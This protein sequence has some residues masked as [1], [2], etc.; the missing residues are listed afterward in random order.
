[1]HYEAFRA[2]WND[3]LRASRLPTVGVYPSETLDTRDL[4]RNYEVVVE[5]LGGQ[6]AS[7]F[8]VTARLSWKWSSLNTVRNATRDEDVLVEMLGRDQASEL[9]IEKPYVPVDIQ[10]R[11]SA[12]YAKPLPMPGRAAWAKWVR[13]TLQRLDH[14]E[15]LLPDEVLRENRMGMTEVLAWQEAPKLK[16]VCSPN[17]ELSLEAV[18]LSAGQIIELPRSLDC[19]DELDEAPDEQLTELFARVRASLMAWTQAVD[20]LGRR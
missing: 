8:H 4:D 13:E 9:V 18:E 20:H 16:A 6:D 15:P 17:G 5:P 19:P 11:A 2:A 10:L 3:A 12:P 14:I 7:P 1:M